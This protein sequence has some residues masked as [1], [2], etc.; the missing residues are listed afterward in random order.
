MSIF[1]LTCCRDQEVNAAPL[2]R[3]R[4][5]ALKERGNA[6]GVV[7]VRGGVAPVRHKPRRALPFLRLEPEPGDLGTPAG[8]QERGTGTAGSRGPRT[9]HRGSPQPTVERASTLQ[10]GDALIFFSQC[11][12]ESPKP[13]DFSS[14]RLRSHEPS[15]NPFPDR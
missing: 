1:F 15:C 14:P 10:G 9:S 5:S 7:A 3:F 8:A 4:G 6:G 12:R 13:Q 2:Q 11:Y